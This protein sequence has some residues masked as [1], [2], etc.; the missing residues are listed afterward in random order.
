[1]TLQLFARISMDDSI[2]ANVSTFAAE[3]RETAFILRNVSRGSMVIVD[4]LGRGTSPRDGMAIALAVCEALVESR[5]LVWFATHFRELTQILAERSGVVNL[6]MRVEVGS[7][8]FAKKN[9]GMTVRTQMEA[10]DKMTMLYKIADGSVK[11][12][13]YGL[14]LAR[15]VQLP[16]SIIERAMQVSMALTKRRDTAKKNSEAYRVARKRKLVMK[17]FETLVQARNG[18]LD[19]EALKSWLTRVMEDFVE[20]MGQLSESVD[21]EDSEESEK[22]DEDEMEMEMESASV[23]QD[24]DEEM[25]DEE[26]DGDEEDEEEDE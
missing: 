16:Q 23:E 25:E 17:L 2:E 18:R 12:E 20:R 6:H 7:P 22:G 11:D 3:M 26:E 10:Q 4:E 1:M 24:E 15:V 21:G 13:H 9:C 19:D 5:A 8:V 14:V